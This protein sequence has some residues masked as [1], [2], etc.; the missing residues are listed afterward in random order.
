MASDRF[1]EVHLPGTADAGS[2]RVARG[3]TIADAMRLAGIP[4]NTRCGGRGICDGC[5][6]D[7]VEGQVTRATTRE[8]IHAEAGEGEA[9]PIRGCQCVVAPD[10]SDHLARGEQKIVLCVPPRSLLAYQPQVV[11][12]FRTNVSRV[13]DPLWQQC[14]VE[15]EQWAGDPGRFVQAIIRDRA[16]R[17]PLRPEWEDL[18]ADVPQSTPLFATI[19]RRPDCWLLTAISASPALNALGAAIDIGTTTVA[20]LLI[21]L[22]SATVVGRAAQFNRQMQLGDDVLTRI[23]LC[24]NDAGNVAELQRAVIEQTIAPL[25]REALAQA[26]ASEME[27]L[28]CCVIAGNTTML[29]LLA[30]IDPA[31]M[32]TSPFTPV[33]LE[34]RV[35]RAEQLAAWPEDLAP[36]CDLHLLPGPAAYVGADLSAG[37]LASGLLYDDGPSLLVDVGTN[38]EIVLKNGGQLTGCATAAGP[39]FE[40]AGLSSGVRAGDGAIGHLHLE[41]D[42]PAVEL[43]IVGGQHK[44]KPIGVCGSGY[45]DFL[46]EGRRVG[47]LNH[48]GRFDV[49]PGH[50]LASR[51]AAIPHAGK[52]FFLTTPAGDGSAPTSIAQGGVTSDRGVIVT[53]A[54][55]A[56]LLAAKAAIAAGVLILLQRQGLSTKDVKKVYLAGGF[57]THMSARH[58]IGCGLLPGFAPQQIQ[59]IGNSALAGAFLA[60]LDSTALDEIAR[61]CH[62]MEIVDLNLDPAFEDTYVEQLCL[63][64]A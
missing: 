56:R 49:E 23:N 52:G 14:R 12:D 41:L 40:G 51:I 45:I 16:L 57:G 15:W 32:G 29:H 61:A 58:A 42:P 3:A 1:V 24:C 28:K 38:G 18:F 36:D 27:R 7:L 8:I 5:M 2:V 50:P 17:L 47:L 30:G 4:L 10:S 53:E 13:N 20:V 63:P 55:I 48:V 44:R 9:V 22:S 6:V 31:P 35:Y 37:I 62:G 39:A 43:D 21:E 19:Q 60:L 46:G 25:L 54:D 26:G 11:T 64:E 59:P 33:F 34:H